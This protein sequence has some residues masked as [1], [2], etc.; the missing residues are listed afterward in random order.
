MFDLA[1]LGA[2]PSSQQRQVPPGEARVYA[3][4]TQA[5]TED[6]KRLLGTG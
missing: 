1:D 2:M 6:F 3:D 4:F 5:V